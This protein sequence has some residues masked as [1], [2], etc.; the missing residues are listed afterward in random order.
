M[1]RSP[2]DFRWR[3]ALGLASVVVLVAIYAGLS[4]RQHQ[5]N[6]KDTTMPGW[7]QLADGWGKM[8]TPHHRSGDVWLTEDAIATGKRLGA[9][10]AAG[11]AGAMVLGFLMGCW[12]PAESFLVPPLTILGKL[13]P[14][15]ML[16]VFFVIFGLEMKMYVAMIAFG[17][18]PPMAMTI[19]LAIKNDVPEELIH[20]SYTLGASHL[21]IVLFVIFRQ[22]LPKIFEGVRLQTGPALVYLIAAEM[23]VGDV[24]F[25]YRIRLE[26]RLLH[27]NVVYPYIMLLAMFGYSVDLGLRRLQTFICPWYEHQPEGASMWE[28]LRAMFR[29]EVASSE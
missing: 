11:I 2:I 5:L 8:T 6:P 16:A 4:A 18:L 15:A 26:S 7:S 12:A 27:M 28:S 19:Y 14:I 29:G 9:G 3:A 22:I 20:K 24:G 23:V 1:I 17:I 25:G 10:M 13:N 21:E